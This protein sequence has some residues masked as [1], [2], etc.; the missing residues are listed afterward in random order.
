MNGAITS[1]NYDCKR[2]SF[3]DWVRLMMSGKQSVTLI[4]P[5]KMYIVD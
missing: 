1:A 2:N 4:L 3:K 5:R